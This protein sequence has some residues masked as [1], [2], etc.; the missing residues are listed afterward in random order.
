[1]ALL[2]ALLLAPVSVRVWQEDTAGAR[3]SYLFFR[4]TL[5]PFPKRPEQEPKQKKQIRD[6][7]PKAEKKAPAFSA[8]EILEL[9]GLLLPRLSRTA[10]RLVR[11]TTLARVTLDLTVGRGDAAQTA[12]EFGKMNGRVYAA[13]AF[14][15]NFVKVRVKR[16]E[17][18]PD[19][20]AERDQYRFSV[21]VRTL[22]ITLLAAALETGFWVLWA[23]VKSAGLRQ[24]K[25][26]RD[27]DQPAGPKE[28]DSPAVPAAGTT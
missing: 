28:A 10:A 7:K 23:A 22:P 11:R 12:I 2:A 8:K 14:F 25:P 18:L 17:V 16:I 13:L 21:T 1:M 3:L 6:K 26:R 9:L 24:R 5:F 27:G 4:V 15:Q 20:T 19:F